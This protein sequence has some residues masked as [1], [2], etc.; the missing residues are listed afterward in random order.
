MVPFFS[1][2]L[3]LKSSTFLSENIIIWVKT[4]PCFSQMMIFSPNTSFWTKK[5]C[6]LMT[7]SWRLES[8]R[9]RARG[10]SNHKFRTLGFYYLLDMIG[11]FQISMSKW[12]RE[13]QL[14]MWYFF[15]CTFSK[16]I[17]PFFQFIG[18]SHH[19]C[20]TA[21]QSNLNFPSMNVH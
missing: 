13:L 2:S 20:W 12:S 6:H 8:E 15:L 10:K 9:T 18:Y 5:R 16:V 19:I 7:F 1:R 11:L 4:V 3:G 14:C 21:C 17:S